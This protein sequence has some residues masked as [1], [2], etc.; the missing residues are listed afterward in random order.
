MKKLNVDIII[1]EKKNSIAI[2]V[3]NGEFMI[4]HNNNPVIDRLL[5]YLDRPERYKV[6]VTAHK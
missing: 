4:Y 2:S 3:D 6:T 1:D 5:T